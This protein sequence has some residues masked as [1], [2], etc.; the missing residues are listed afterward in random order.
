MPRTNLSTRY[1]VVSSGNGNDGV[2][3]LFPNYIVKTDR[4]WA[5][6]RLA[7]LTTFKKGKG[8]A[9]CEENLQLDG[10]AEYTIS[11]VLY[12]SPET[13]DER[14]AMQDRAESELRRFEQGEPDAMTEDE[15][16][17]LESEIEGY[18]CNYAWNIF[19]VFPWDE[20]DST[21]RPVFESLEDAFGADCALVKEET[22]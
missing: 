11:A 21:S 3:H 7:A 10:E 14:A 15:I 22:E 4:P 2:S 16:G 8:Q 12:E 9:W 18:G 20:T 19:E 13:Q 1:Y 17:A 5:L 6:A